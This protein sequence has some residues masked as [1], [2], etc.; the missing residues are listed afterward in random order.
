MEDVNGTSTARE[1]RCRSCAMLLGIASGSGL[2]LRYKR[3]EV[4]ARG[5]VT[6]LC[7]RCGTLT[8]AAAPGKALG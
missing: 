3:F 7:R 1:V 5:A 8:E 6:I 4:V 2:R